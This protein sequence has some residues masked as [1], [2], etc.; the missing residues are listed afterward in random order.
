MAAASAQAASRPSRPSAHATGGPG[1]GA[2]RRRGDGVLADLRDAVLLPADG[3]AVGGHGLDGDRRV[4]A[5]GA[6]GQGLE[7]QGIDSPA[8]RGELAERDG[9]PPYGIAPAA[10]GPRPSGRSGEGPLWAMPRGAR[11]KTRPRRRA[12]ARVMVI[13]V[14]T[15]GVRPAPGGGRRR[16]WDKVV[17]GSTG[18]PV[19]AAQAA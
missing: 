15:S 2:G 17:A 14:R 3:G 5:A 7:G 13:T 4:A 12:R 10:P 19:A 9:Q 8:G 18:R 6:R 16:V 1:K 11:R